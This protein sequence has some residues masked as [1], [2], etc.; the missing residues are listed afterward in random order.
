MKTKKIAVL[1]IAALSVTLAAC[2]K[3]DAETA[4][5]KDLTEECSFC[6]GESM[7]LNSDGMVSE[8]YAQQVPFYHYGNVAITPQAV[9]N[10]TLLGYY[11]YHEGMSIAFNM[12]NLPL[13]C[14]SNKITFVHARMVSNTNDDPELVNVQFPGTPLIVTVPDS[15]NYFLSPYGYTAQHFFHPGTVF[16]ESVPGSSFPGVIDSMII[17]GPEF[18]TVTV[19]ANLFESELR[20]ICV[21]HQ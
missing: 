10:K 13:A 17:T 18:E 5:N 12:A 9:A 14:T 20:S 7:E 8:T 21:S 15:L 16:Q 1:T 2:K 3:D 6:P 4:V 11:D 19:G